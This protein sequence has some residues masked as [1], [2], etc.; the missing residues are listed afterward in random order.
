MNAR[1]LNAR[2]NQGSVEATDC[3]ADDLNSIGTRS[4][5]H[6]VKLHDFALRKPLFQFG[7]HSDFCTEEDGVDS[8]VGFSDHKG[9]SFKVRVVGG[10]DIG[11]GVHSGMVLRVKHSVCMVD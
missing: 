5:L 9:G 6:E 4:L 7:N 10:N 2:F 11:V 3:V 1:A 8:S